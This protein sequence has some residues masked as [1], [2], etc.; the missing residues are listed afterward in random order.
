MT[1]DKQTEIGYRRT[2]S[3]LVYLAT[4]SVNNL[5]KRL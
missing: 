5:I 4:V 1:L 2:S 3:F